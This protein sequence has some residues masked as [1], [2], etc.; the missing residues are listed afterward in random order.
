MIGESAQNGAARSP[1]RGVRGR[2]RARDG[3]LGSRSRR[4]DPASRASRPPP[5]ARRG[6]PRPSDAPC[7]ASP[8]TTSRRPRPPSC[9]SCGASRSRRSRAAAR[10]V[11]HRRR[12][13]AARARAAR[14]LG[15]QRRRA[16]RAAL[17]DAGR[18]QRAPR[19]PPD[20]EWLRAL[21]LPDFPV[22]WER[23]GAA[24][25]RLLQERSQGACGD[26]ELAAPRGPLPRAVRQGARAPRAAARSRSTSRWSRAA[27][28][29][30]ARSRVGAGGVWQF[31]PGAARA[32][33]LEVSYWIDARRDPER[34]AEAA[35]RYLKDLYVRFGSW[36][37]VVRRVQRRL[38]R[39]AALDH[40]LQHQRLLGAGPARVGPALGVERLR[41]EDP[42][43]GDRGPQPGRVRVRRRDARSRR[44]PT[45]RSR[46]PRA[47]RWR[48]WRA[49]RA[50]RPR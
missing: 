32:Y 46:F 38:R 22:R 3:G 33:G 24:L 14:E 2:D 30:C 9:A 7:A 37:L 36:P 27:S 28:T 11:A 31:M 50:R 8:S 43:G 34:A 25:P 17:A 47:R 12:C 19:P 29:A 45:T 48:R 40:Q 41:P 13:R 20:S 6:E 18:R 44:S 4:R 1:A 42:R 23:A 35:A 10:R 15:R 5:A 49:R 21:K 39:R 26:V 16:A